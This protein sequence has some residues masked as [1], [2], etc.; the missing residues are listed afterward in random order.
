VKKP[1]L[2]GLGG[3]A[4]VAA[5]AGAFFSLPYLTIHSM[6]D[7]VK[8]GNGADLVT[9]VDFPSLR[10]SIKSNLDATVQSTLSRVGAGPLGAWGGALAESMASSIV[11][12]MV[13]PEGVMKMMGGEKPTSTA[14]MGT[15]PQVP[16][17]PSAPSLSMGYA[18]L[19]TFLVDASRAEGTSPLRLIFTRQGLTWKL[20]GVRF[21]Q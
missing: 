15:A 21:P 10:A 9:H 19:D 12:A 14:A 7:D 8:T 5:V 2:L 17:Q 3:V 4:I 18:S 11:D 13:T 20:S 1:V 16:V 6:Y